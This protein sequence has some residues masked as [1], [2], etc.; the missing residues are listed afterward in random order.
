[1]ILSLVAP[2]LSGEITFSFVTPLPLWDDP[3][4]TPSEVYV[5]TR[6]DSG[7]PPAVTTTTI[8]APLGTPAGTTVVATIRDL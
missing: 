4:S 7:A 5:I 3:L 8:T 6:T 2:H 1:M